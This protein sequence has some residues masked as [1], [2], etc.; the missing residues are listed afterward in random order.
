MEISISRFRQ[1]SK[2]ST[3]HLQAQPVT[4]SFGIVY[5]GYRRLDSICHLGFLNL[6]LGIWEQ[7]FARFTKKG[8]PGRRRLFV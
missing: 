1:V 5:T 4:L 6:K 8:A 7:S 3:Y 2:G